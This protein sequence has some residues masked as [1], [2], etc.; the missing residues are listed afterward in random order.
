MQQCCSEEYKNSSLLEESGSIELNSSS[1]SGV[2]SSRA[3]NSSAWRAPSRVIA[4]L[5]IL[6]WI[7]ALSLGAVSLSPLDVVGVRA[8]TPIVVKPLVSVSQEADL[9]IFEQT[10]EFLRTTPDAGPAMEST[11]PTSVSMVSLYH[12]INESVYFGNIYILDPNSWEPIDGYQFFV[13]RVYAIPGNTYTGTNTFFYRKLQS[14]HVQSLPPHQPTFTGSVELRFFI[15][16]LHLAYK[17]VPSPVVGYFRDTYRVSGMWCTSTQAPGVDV[18]LT[19]GFQCERV[20]SSSWTPPAV[21]LLRGDYI[22]GQIVNVRF[23]HTP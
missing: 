4:L 15:R 10:L 17:S 8:Q 23:D 3:N 22:G 21:V 13:R 5:G 7:G 16:G 12:S 18:E 11:N 2:V 6:T 9:Q 20:F 14:T 19:M 1:S